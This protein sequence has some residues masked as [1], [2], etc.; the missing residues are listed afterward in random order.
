M[1]DRAIDAPLRLGHESRSAA[2]GRVHLGGRLGKENR[3][4]V[5]RAHKA[6]RQLR[7]VRLRGA[8]ERLDDE[9]LAAQIAEH[10]V[11][12][13]EQ[14]GSIGH[15]RL[16]LVGRVAKPLDGIAGTGDGLLRLVDPG[17]SVRVRIVD[18]ALRDANFLAERVGDRFRDGGDERGV[19]RG[20]E[21][22]RACV[23]NLR[24]HGVHLLVHV[25]LKLR[26]LE[27]AGEQREQ[28]G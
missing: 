14:R 26:L 13:G 10:L 8:H 5:H 24:R 4:R 6:R 23:G 17:E 25:V 16:R 9:H 3:P 2:D 11:R 20:V 15:L 1:C 12:I 27:V 28:V 7:D 22:V 19:D 18:L 21:R